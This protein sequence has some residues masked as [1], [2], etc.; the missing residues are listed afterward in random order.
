MPNTGN[1]TVNGLINRSDTITTSI[2]TDL[3]ALDN[4]ANLTTGTLMEKSYTLSDSQFKLGAISS[5][6]KTIPDNEQLV[7]SKTRFGQSA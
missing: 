5:V 3:K 1:D 4:T 7:M 6:I 2:E